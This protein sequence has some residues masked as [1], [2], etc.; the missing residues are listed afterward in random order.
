MNSPFK[1]QD[2]SALIAGIIL[3]SVAAGTIAYLFTTE[4]G[5][6]VRKQL[7][8]KLTKLLDK[9]TGKLE[10]DTHPG[11]VHHETFY[12]NRRKVKAPKSDREKILKHEILSHHDEPG[13]K[14][15]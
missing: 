13:H 6:A 11:H 15:E 9:L 10:T 4:N 12:Q 5:N 1:K 2:N 3:S 7:K 8:E 14:V